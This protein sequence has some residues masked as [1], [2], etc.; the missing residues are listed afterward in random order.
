MIGDWDWGSVLVK[1]TNE[2]RKDQIIW[3]IGLYIGIGWVPEVNIETLFLLQM[4]GGGSGD[5]FW[6]KKASERAKDFGGF[7]K[8]GLIKYISKGSAGCTMCIS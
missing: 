6:S 1:G 8:P 7:V 2:R 4:L 5:L 3:E